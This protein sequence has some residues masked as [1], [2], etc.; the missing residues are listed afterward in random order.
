MELKP[1]YTLTFDQLAALFNEA[2]A[3]YV[4]GDVHF[5]GSALAGWIAH[6]NI[7]L[8]LSQIVMHDDQIAGFGYIARHGG[9]CRLAAFGIVPSAAHQGIGKA[10]MV[11]L[12]AQARQ[13]GD[14]AFH[15]E[16]IEQNPRAVKL[17]QG[18]GFETLR[19]LVGYK[20]VNPPSA[21]DMGT[22]AELIDLATAARSIVRYEARDL[23][24]QINGLAILQLSPPNV[25][26]RLSEATAI[27]SD[28]SS[29]TVV[30]RSLIVAPESRRHG[31][32]TQ[33]LSALFAQFPEKTWVLSAVYP[34]EYVTPLAEKF[35]FERTPIS[36]WQM[37]LTLL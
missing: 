16:V 7:D 21:T 26:Y 30:I 17:Y 35:A 14:S 2:F 36:Q 32:A 29:A 12:I 34:E 28:P 15:L 1:A 18:V 8:S 5:T 9:E 6:E 22:R 4:G 27:L 3:G 19:R 20:G 10:A 31:E 33:L 13:R 25:A 24:W 11:E 23:P 37:R